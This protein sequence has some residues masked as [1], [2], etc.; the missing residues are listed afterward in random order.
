MWGGLLLTLGD[1]D[2]ISV[3]QIAPDI[4]TR[5]G[6][7]AT[8]VLAVVEGLRVDPNVVVDSDEPLQFLG[9]AEDVHGDRMRYVAHDL[10]RHLLYGLSPQDYLDRYL[11]GLP[12]FGIES[13]DV[14]FVVPVPVTGVKVLEPEKRGMAWQ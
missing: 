9:L 13:Q 3:I 8:M 1:G 10:K 14:R 4:I 5:N 11:G 2:E 7:P 6:D 12:L